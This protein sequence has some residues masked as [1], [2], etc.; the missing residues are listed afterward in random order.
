VDARGEQVTDVGGNLLHRLRDLGVDWLP[1][2]RTNTTNLH[3]LWYGVYDHRVYH[4]GAGF[5]NQVARIDRRAHR[6]LY[7]SLTVE[8]GTGPSVEV[9]R[10]ALKE[11]PARLVRARPR[12]ISMAARAMATSL[13]WRRNEWYYARRRRFR[14]EAEAQSDEIFARV[15]DDPSFYRRFD[16][17][18]IEA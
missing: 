18:E 13:R 16:D 6:H 12:H 15:K 3:P 5:R 10:R 9:L 4:H 17:A 7:R 1:L 11:R 2:L 14:A 8:E